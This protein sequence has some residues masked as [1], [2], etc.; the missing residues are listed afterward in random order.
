MPDNKSPELQFAAEQDAK[1]DPKAAKKEEKKKEAPLPVL[2]EFTI[3]VCVI[4]LAAVFL[5]IVGVSLYT[6]V[7]LSA[8]VIRTSVSVLALGLLLALLARQVIQGMKAAGM[9]GSDKSKK[10]QAK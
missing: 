7:S 3:T 1:P 9:L 5:V 6:G 2:V 8:F 10:G 4:I